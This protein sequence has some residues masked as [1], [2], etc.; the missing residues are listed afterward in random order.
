MISRYLYLNSYALL[1]LFVGGGIL[2]LPGWKIHW[3]V[4]LLQV[5]VA[6]PFV[7]NGIRILASWE[8]KMREYNLLMQRN[9]E[10]FNPSSFAKFMEAPCGRLLVKVVLRDLGCSDKYESLKVYR[11]SLW[12]AFRNGLLCRSQTKTTVHFFDDKRGA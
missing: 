12:Q 6:Y 1:L 2:L 11:I 9:A 4:V 3:S 8:H 10:K 7:K 5:A